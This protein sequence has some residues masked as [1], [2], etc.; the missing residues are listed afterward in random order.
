MSTYGV[1]DFQRRVR[2]DTPKS[3]SAKVTAIASLTYVLADVYA[4][5]DTTNTGTVLGNFT[6]RDNE[7]PFRKV[8][9]VLDVFEDAYGNWF[10]KPES[11]AVFIGKVVSKLSAQDEIDQG[12]LGSDVGRM[13]FVDLFKDG[14]DANGDFLTADASSRVPVRQLQQTIRSGIGAHDP[15]QPTAPPGTMALVTKAGGRFYMQ[16]AVF[17]G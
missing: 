10:V 4:T 5:G 2:R 3:L 7:A 14:A 16:I 6:I 8:G 13:Y 12:F 15:N 1:R 11:A 9:D 17:L